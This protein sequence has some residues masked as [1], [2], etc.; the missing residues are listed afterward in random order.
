MSIR[1]LGSMRRAGATQKLKS[2]DLN[3]I[4]EGDDEGIE[5]QTL[6]NEFHKGQNLL[7]K[8]VSQLDDR[9]QEVQFLRRESLSSDKKSSESS[10]CIRYVRK[11]SKIIDDYSPKR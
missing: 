9:E 3:T 11:K 5:S 4:I 10:E 7:N 6:N 1:G 8:K 2:S